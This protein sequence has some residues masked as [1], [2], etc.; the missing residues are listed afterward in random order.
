LEAPRKKPYEDQRSGELRRGFRR[1]GGT[2]LR[3]Q[4][5]YQY[6]F[7]ADGDGYRRDV[8]HRPGGNAGVISE[9]DRRAAGPRGWRPIRPK[10]SPVPNRNFKPLSFSSRQQRADHQQ[11]N[12]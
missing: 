11:S 2:R 9:L 10:W 4:S 12:G 5:G 1:R 8:Q 3:K 7:Q 6:R